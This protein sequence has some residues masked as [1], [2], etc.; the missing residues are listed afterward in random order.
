MINYDDNSNDCYLDFPSDLPPQLSLK[1]SAFFQLRE[2][3]ER[4]DCMAGSVTMHVR[5]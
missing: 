4:G 3:W 5:Q 2:A 1:G